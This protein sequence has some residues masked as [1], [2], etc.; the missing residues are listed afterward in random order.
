V[1]RGQEVR[2][3][4]RMGKRPEV[5]KEEDWRRMRQA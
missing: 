1:E 3:R 4:Q 5:E 2:R